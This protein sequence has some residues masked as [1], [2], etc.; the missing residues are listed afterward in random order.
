M[1]HKHTRTHPLALEQKNS[2]THI[3]LT[4]T[5]EHKNTHTHA[6]TVFTKEKKIHCVWVNKGEKESLGLVRD[7]VL[8]LKEET[9]CSEHWQLKVETLSYHLPYSFKML[10]QAEQMNYK[11]IHGIT[12]VIKEVS[13]HLKS[14]YYYIYKPLSALKDGFWIRTQIS[15]K[16]TA[17]L[18]SALS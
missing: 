11:W 15:R 16:R 5:I 18:T 17:K 8:C 6:P 9:F 14:I 1:L 7:L 4:L 12:S 13:G 10:G 2:H 3:A